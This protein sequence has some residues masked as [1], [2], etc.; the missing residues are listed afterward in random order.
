MAVINRDHLS[1]EVGHTSGLSRI[2]LTVGLL[3]VGG[4]VACVIAG[5]ALGMNEARS[6]VVDSEGSLWLLPVGGAAVVVGLVLASIG[7]AWARRSAGE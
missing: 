7:M 5:I 3:L 1:R 4:G 6:G 2:V